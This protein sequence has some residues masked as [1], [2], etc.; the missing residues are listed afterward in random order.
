M[1]TASLVLGILSLGCAFALPGFQLI[2][3]LLAVIGL[4]TG[5]KNAVPEQASMAKAGKVCSIIGL[6]LCTVVTAVLVISAG[7]LGAFVST[8]IL[9]ELGELIQAIT[10]D[11]T[12]S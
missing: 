11:I 5:G 4:I 2:G 6:I 12:L 9:E 3:I 10:K 8:G 7:L 1:A